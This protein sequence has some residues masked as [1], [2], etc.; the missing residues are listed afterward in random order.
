[1]K[2][3][4]SSEPL[5]LEDGA[6]DQPFLV[7]VVVVVEVVRVYA[8]ASVVTFTSSLLLLLTY[9][10]LSTQWMNGAL[11]ADV[12]LLEDST[13][14]RKAVTSAASKSKMMQV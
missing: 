3:D 5:V 12:G 10:L 7:D 1:M 14:F 2:E 6:D 11:V 13:A 8:D 4:L 9:S